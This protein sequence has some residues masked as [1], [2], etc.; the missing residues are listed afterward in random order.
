VREVVY[1]G[2]GLH[3]FMESGGLPLTSFLQNDSG[4]AS[5]WSPGE[6]VSVDFEPDSVVVLE[7]RRAS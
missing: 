2:A 3:V 5:G 6:T 4:A 1:R 7:G